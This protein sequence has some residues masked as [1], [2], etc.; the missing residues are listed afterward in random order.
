M[1][2]PLRTGRKCP[3]NGNPVGGAAATPIVASYRDEIEYS[4]YP[5]YIRDR[6]ERGKRGNKCTKTCL[7]IRGGT[8]I[9][10]F[11]FLF[12]FIF[13][14]QVGTWV[15]LVNQIWSAFG[16]ATVSFVF[17]YWKNADVYVI[18]KAINRLGDT[19]NMDDCLFISYFT[20]GKNAF[21]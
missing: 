20:Y 6:G 2:N 18:D 11:V 1:Q 17:G 3:S 4:V 5:V 8:S 10:L 14:S 21:L 12:L 7:T 16:P 15:H 19:M 9:L 13:N